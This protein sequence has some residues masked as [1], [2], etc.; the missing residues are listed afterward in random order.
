MSRHARAGDPGGGDEDAGDRPRPRLPW[1]RLFALTR[2]ERGPLAWGT[3]FL[4]TG[5][6]AGLAYPKAFGWL[7]DDLSLPAAQALPALQQHVLAMVGIVLVQSMSVLLRMRIVLSA[8]ARIVARLRQ[9]LFAALLR[10]EVAFFDARRTGELVTR[11][12]AD[13]TVIERSVTTNLSMILRDLI[14]VAGSLALM[15]ATAPLLAGIIV[16][17]VLPIV[18]GAVLVG[19]R[20]EKLSKRGQDALAD[21]GHVAEEVL[22]GLRTVRS[23]AR[24]DV[25]AAR[26]GRSLAS[27]LELALQRVRLVSGFVGISWFFSF[28]ALGIVIWLGMRQIVEGTLTSG[29][30]MQFVLY[31][32]TVAFSLGGIGDVWAEFLSARGA[33]ARIFELLDR[34]PAMA[35]SGGG[36]VPPGKGHVVFSGVRFAYPTRPDAPVLHGLDLELRPGECVALVGPSGAGK[37]TIAALLSRFYD[38]DAGTIRLDGGCL[39]AL[40]PMALREQVGLVAQEPLLFS[41]T[42]EENIRYGKPGASREEVEAAARIANAHDFICALPQGYATAVGERGV[43]LS[44]GQKQRVAIARAVLKD[45]RVLI[46]DEATSAL[47]AESEALVQQALARLLAGRTSLV[48]AHR[49][50]TVRDADRVL[51][52]DAGRVVQD[53][54]HDALV[55]DA[56]GLYARLV[57]RQFELA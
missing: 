15:L 14:L 56:E 48:I 57:Q 31:G 37:S 29:Q 9:D 32:G 53:G 12:A 42:I 44:G 39:S 16:A 43:Q 26:Y 27:N 30:L 51:V 54:R 35:A 7:V 45:P 41:T 52:I 10:Q 36:P 8:G 13:T 40:D 18:V 22:S 49:L 47:D 3:L 6:A 46:L 5:S 24:E 1:R 19:R 4:V 2:P 33:S 55:R 50:S 38:P 21:T 20:I 11:L 25:E 28:A 34:Q 23:F 17:L